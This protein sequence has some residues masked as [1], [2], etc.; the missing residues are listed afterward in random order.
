MI[1]HKRQD[2][3][4]IDVYLCVN[5]PWRVVHIYIYASCMRCKQRDIPSVC[6]E[7]QKIVQGMDWVNHTDKGY[8]GEKYPERKK[9][10]M[11]STA[12]ISATAWCNL[13]G[14]YVLASL[15]D[16]CSQGLLLTTAKWWQSIT[17]SVQSTYLC[18]VRMVSLS[19]QPVRRSD[20]WS[21]LF[22]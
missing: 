2:E 13:S 4:C 1:S 15:F 6:R 17:C 8:P 9:S 18:R 20:F 10:H 11:F 16:A 22:N 19:E 7:K 3:F 5:V 21:W 12:L 14:K